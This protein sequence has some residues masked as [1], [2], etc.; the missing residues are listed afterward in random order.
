MS[1]VAEG[2]RYLCQELHTLLEVVVP[3]SDGL[4][5]SHHRHGEIVTVL[6]LL[7]EL[8]PSA[9]PALQGQLQMLAKQVRLA[10]PQALLFA[11]R[12]DALQEQASR[13][14]GAQAVAL[15][16]WPGCVGLCLA[17]RANTCCQVFILIGEPSPL[18]CWLP[19]TKPCEPGVPWKL[20]IALFGLIWPF[21]AS[22]RLGCSPCSPFGI[23]TALLLAVF[24]RG[25]LPYNGQDQPY[26]LTSGWQPW[27]ILLSLP[28][29]SRVSH[30]FEPCLRITLK[31]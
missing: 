25:F 24:M 11:R 15:L 19:G 20:G 6:D 10:L 13:V 27:A 30:G 26:P 3:R 14:L 16:A 29:C 28:D 23:I 7:D 31:T 22:S 8:V 5:T 21:I 17:Q 2:V 12:L 4:L 1:Y 9:T 18:G